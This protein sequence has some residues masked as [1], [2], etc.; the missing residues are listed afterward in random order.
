L[1]VL[2]QPTDQLLCGEQVTI[3]IEIA[4]DCPLGDYHVAVGFDDI[5]G[6]RLFTAATYLSESLPSP[7]RTMRRFRCTLG[8]LPLCPGRYGITLNAGPRTNV[9][10]D[11]IDQALWFEVTA[12]DFYGNGRLPNPDW[13]RFLVRSAWDPV[14]S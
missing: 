7:D 6:C 14:K 13:G 10:T 2:G 11:M 8:E 3:E 12:T 4:A 1:N 9:W 5:L